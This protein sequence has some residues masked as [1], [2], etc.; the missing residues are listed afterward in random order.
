M[1]APSMMRACGG[2]YEYAGGG[3]VLDTKAT[4]AAI[5]LVSKKVGQITT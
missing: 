4:R 1:K 2:G 5:Y 3:V